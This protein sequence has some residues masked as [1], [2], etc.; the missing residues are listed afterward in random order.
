M[1]EVLNA[2]CR[3]RGLFAHQ[4]VAWQEAFYAGAG[5]QRARPARHGLEAHAMSPHRVTMLLFAALSSGTI[6]AADDSARCYN[7]RDPD[8]HN[9]GAAGIC[10]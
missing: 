6:G 7:I 4:R 3:E 2:W 10:G 5:D 8:L 1:G 9:A